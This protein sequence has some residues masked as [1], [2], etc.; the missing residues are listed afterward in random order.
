MHLSHAIKNIQCTANQRADAIV[1]SDESLRLY[2]TVNQVNRETIYTKKANYLKSGLILV[3][4]YKVTFLSITNTKITDTNW[5]ASKFFS[6]FFSSLLSILTITSKPI[7]GIKHCC[8]KFKYLWIS[9]CCCCCWTVHIHLIEKTLLLEKY[10]PWTM[11]PN[12]FM[13]RTLLVLQS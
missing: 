2:S 8:V 11:G 3:N 6:V 12:G 9:C 13:G 1:Y 7:T 4:V 10:K 5:S